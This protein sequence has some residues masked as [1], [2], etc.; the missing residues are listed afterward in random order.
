MNNIGKRFEIVDCESHKN[1]VSFRVGKETKALRK[2]C[3]WACAILEIKFTKPQALHWC[4]NVAMLVSM[5]AEKG[6]HT[7]FPI[8]LALPF[9]HLIPPRRRE[10]RDI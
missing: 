9:G 10:V 3:K 5:A 1:D 8:L 7:K 6:I 4:F 2:S